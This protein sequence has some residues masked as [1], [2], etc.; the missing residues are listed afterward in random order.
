[1]SVDIYPDFYTMK[2]AHTFLTE[3]PWG[4]LDIK[5][6]QWHPLVMHILDVVG[7]AHQILQS[8][9]IQRRLL[10]SSSK[11]MTDTQ[12]NRICFFVG[13]HDIGKLNRGFQYKSNPTATITNGHVKPAFALVDFSNPFHK[14][15]FED[16]RPG[17]SLKK[18]ISEGNWFGTSQYKPTQK[19]E[20]FLKMFKASISHHGVPESEKNLAYSEFAS[21]DASQKKEV[22]E[23]LNVLWDCLDL[24]VD[25]GIVNDSF[26]ID[27]IHDKN[28]YI[29]LSGLIQFADW[30]GSNQKIF[31]YLD[32]DSKTLELELFQLCLDRLSFAKKQ[33]QRF[34]HSLGWQGLDVI[35]SIKPLLI[36]NQSQKS[37][38]S[39][40]LPF[41]KLHP[42]QSKIFD[43]YEPGVT[44]IIEAQ[45]GGGKTEIAALR[46]LQNFVNR[47]VSGLLLALPSVASARQIHSRLTQIFEKAFGSG[48]PKIVLA[49]GSD[50]GLFNLDIEEA[51][52]KID[53]NLLLETLS[54]SGL[55][56]DTDP[57]H[58]V[59][60]LWATDSSKKFLAAPI[61][62]CTVDQLIMSSL[63]IKHATMR[64]FWV[65]R[66]FV[67]VDEVH[68]FDVYQT[69]HLK[70]TLHDHRDCGGVS[71][72]LSATLTDDIKSSLLGIPSR[73][74]TGRENELHTVPYPLLT[75][76]SIHKKI[77]EIPL[78]FTSEKEFYVDIIDEFD[79]NIVAEQ[80]LNMALH[81]AN[82]CIIKN[83]VT[84][85]IE[86]QKS[87]ELIAHDSR[88]QSN[89]LLFSVNTIACPFHSRYTEGDK[90]AICS[91]LDIDFGVNS[92][93]K[94]TGRVIVATQVIQQSLDIDFDIMMS[95][96]AP[97]SLLLQRSGRLH[98]HQKKRPSGFE[99]AKLL[100]LSPKTLFNSNKFNLGQ[101]GLGTV[102]PYWM[103][104]EAT[105]IN[106]QEK[107]L[108]LVNQES[109][110]R[111]ETTSN[112]LVH[113]YVKN[114][115]G[116]AVFKAMRD[117]E[118]KANGED[119][120]YRNTAN[121]VNF[122]RY[123]GMS[124]RSFVYNSSN[125][126]A[127]ST[128]LGEESVII[129]IKPNTQ[130]TKNISF[131][132][133]IDGFFNRITVPI[134]L[135][136]NIDLSD[137][138][139]G[140]ITNVSSSSLHKEYEIKIQQCSLKYSR[141]GINKA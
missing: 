20:I 29:L 138:L 121:F 86:V 28:F 139:E 64:S 34:L 62:I 31:H 53:A 130:T 122:S 57:R 136:P 66:F 9:I 90:K 141:F 107:N 123:D 47:Q 96:L 58:V 91:Q 98:R 102:Y 17:L 55:W 95:D 25:S 103:Q 23:I 101:M 116:D 60:N 52:G 1:M 36:T 70:K 26:N 56:D 80:A 94:P 83:T 12:I 67:I 19:L 50:V 45:T 131:P 7:F 22:D 114:K 68:S 113:T 120:A 73:T 65:S 63:Q 59:S 24:S 21:W 124:Y 54:H 112:S 88:F 69:E 74:K 27:S 42:F 106:I 119:I 127:I 97:M 8:P 6:N 3:K 140:F 14:I 99:Q 109:R 104:L 40:I 126:D 108:F 132:C 35:D 2:L 78:P 135:L 72:L 38:F 61:V 89:N 84:G 51:N 77:K 10:G 71:L 5:K 32:V 128:R 110:W 4:K 33:S 118:L 48:C 85:C 133:V 87:L 13:L 81:G 115:A 93:R 16:F 92:Q 30:A 11:T 125:Q 46:G 75:Q 105:L 15:L 137:R 117:M 44:E 39:I 111:I 41:A 43:S 134:R 49:T 37:D 129:D 100:V 82:V 79:P 76:V 18:I